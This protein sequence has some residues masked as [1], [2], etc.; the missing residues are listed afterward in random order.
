M[1]GDVR[2]AILGFGLI[3][4]SIAR[5]LRVHGGASS[6][7]DHLELVAWS[8]HADGPTRALEAGIVDRAAPDPAL[9]IEGADLIV[10]AAPPLASLALV[11]MLAGAM[12]DALGREATVTDVS[13]TKR[14]IGDAADSAGL[15]FVGGHP[16]A[17][18]EE[19]GFDAASADLFVDR[20]WVV[21]AGRHATQGDT[22]RVAAL[23]RACR[24]DPILMDPATHDRLTAMVS[25]VPLVVSAALVEA[26]TADPSWPEARR[27]GAGG[28]QSMSRLAAGDP[29][30]G[31]G[32]AATNAPAIAAGLREVRAALDGWIAAL[33]TD[34][35]PG[36]LETRLRSARERLRS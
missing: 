25:H 17:G 8:R 1:I 12:R 7:A 16:M 2:I 28:W 23:A 6:L 35:D 33:E 24:A 30:M 32:I 11:D 15:R 31:A 27:L 3:G 14:A 22:D 5:A 21:C 10:L 36:D 4:G 19:S 9:A 18:R 26:V 34:T 13:S 20:P 29:T